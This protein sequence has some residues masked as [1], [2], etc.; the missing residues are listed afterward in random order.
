M[1][2][3]SRG[4]GKVRS[5]KARGEFRYPA[6]QNNRSFMSYIGQSMHWVSTRYNGRGAT[7]TRY[8]YIRTRTGCPLN[9]STTDMVWARSVGHLGRGD[10]GRGDLAPLTVTDETYGLLS[11]R[12]G[13]RWRCPNTFGSIAEGDAPLRC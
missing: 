9:L 12:C 7:K 10:L 4:E 5:D 1:T 13:M 8:S 2:R 3:W 11:P 6:Q